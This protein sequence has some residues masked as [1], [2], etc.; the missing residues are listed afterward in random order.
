MMASRWKIII[1][2]YFFRWVEKARNR[3]RN[4]RSYV[5]S[6]CFERDVFMYKNIMYFQYDTRTRTNRTL[7][8]K[9]IPKSLQKGKRRRER[10]RTTIR[11]NIMKSWENARMLLFVATN[12]SRTVQSHFIHFDLSM[13]EPEPSS[14][15]QQQQQK[16][17]TTLRMVYHDKGAI[18]TGMCSA[19]DRPQVPRFIFLASPLHPEFSE[20]LFFH[21][22]CLTMRSTEYRF[23]ITILLL[24]HLV[25]GV[26]CMLH[27]PEYF[28]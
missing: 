1:Y 23:I 9:D 26:A 7:H 4:I 6:M 15:E 17:W 22:V 5:E 8:H 18:E 3:A 13:V 11:R 12:V 20:S 19:F 16:G 28:L 21:R 14:A 2:Y 27:I 24:Q 25:F 10:E